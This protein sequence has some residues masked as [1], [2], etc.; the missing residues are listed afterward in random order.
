MVGGVKWGPGFT[1]N[2]TNRNKTDWQ[3]DPKENENASRP[4]HASITV[5]SMKT[6]HSIEHNLGTQ[7]KKHTNT[8]SRVTHELDELSE[9][10]LAITV[11]VDVSH[12]LLCSV[13]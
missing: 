8:L 11:G 13:K 10:D 3:H 6:L 12:D 4:F 7:N 1:T 5:Q 2:V 9:V